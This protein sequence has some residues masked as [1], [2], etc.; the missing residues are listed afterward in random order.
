M[1]QLTTKQSKVLIAIKEF[2]EANGFSPTIR[3]LM[4]IFGYKHTRSIIDKLNSMEARG[5][6]SRLLFIPRSIVVNVL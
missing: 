1:K 2:I 3:E 4:D 6:I 5:Y